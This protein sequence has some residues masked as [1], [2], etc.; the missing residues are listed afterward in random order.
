L[1]QG[2]KELERYG[3]F[4]FISGRLIQ[5]NPAN[6][7]QVMIDQANDWQAT[8]IYVAMEEQRTT[9]QLKST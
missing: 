2:L 1:D 7:T 4:D 5:S 6:L 9:F 3:E 8:T